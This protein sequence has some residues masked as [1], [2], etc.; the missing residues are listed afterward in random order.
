VGATRG[1]G[2][3]Q[4]GAAHTVA[5]Q[6]RRHLAADL[7]MKP[8]GLGAGRCPL[9]RPPGLELAE[10][11]GGRVLSAVGCMVRARSWLRDAAKCVT[12]RRQAASTL[13]RLILRGSS[14]EGARH[15]SPRQ[16]PGYDG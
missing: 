11:E 3:E 14:P 1:D 2:A 7:V 13:F 6:D 12:P 16:R 15:T 10:V 5:T 8:T 4:I 9:A